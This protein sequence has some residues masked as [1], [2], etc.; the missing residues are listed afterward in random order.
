M[1]YTALPLHSGIQEFWHH[2]WYHW[3]LMCLTRAPS[4]HSAAKFSP[5]LCGQIW[6]NT[7][8]HFSVIFPCVTLVFVPA[9]DNHVPA[10]TQLH[11]QLSALMRC[12][13]V[14]VSN[15]FWIFGK[16]CFRSNFGPQWRSYLLE[17]EQVNSCL[18]EK[19]S[20]VLFLLALEKFSKY[21]TAQWKIVNPLENKHASLLY[22]TSWKYIFLKYR[23]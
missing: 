3:T 2:D 12:T 23:I 11:K 18:T 21:P 20:D 13:Y 8:I 14:Y 15:V 16:H 4:P 5:S 1:F 10:T 19:W 17:K 7:K 6:A 22:L 9:A